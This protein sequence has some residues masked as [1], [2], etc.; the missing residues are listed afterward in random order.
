MRKNETK[1][2]GEKKTQK[3]LWTQN[4]NCGVLDDNAT[5]YKKHKTEWERESD[6]MNVLSAWVGGEGS[7]KRVIGKK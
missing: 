4:R 7:W 3:N 5:R 1:K 2:I 6:E